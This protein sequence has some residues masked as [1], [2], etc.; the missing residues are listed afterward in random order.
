[1]D[2]IGAATALVLMSPVMVLTALAVRLTSPGPVL[3]T[4]PRVGMTQH[5]LARRADPRK[6]SIFEG[7]PGSSMR[8]HSE[9]PAA[10][11]RRCIPPGG[12]AGPFSLY[13]Y[14]PRALA[15]AVLLAMM[16][17]QARIIAE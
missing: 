14:A 12:V 9:S 7:F 1:M 16:P 5:E 11:D 17:D 2:V 6:P 8:V 4:Q 15:V 13:S 3:F 10:F